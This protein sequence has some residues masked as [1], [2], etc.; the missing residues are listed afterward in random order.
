MFTVV[1][2]DNSAWIQGSVF[3][4]HLSLM[5]PFVN[6]HKLFSVNLY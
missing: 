1:C 4:A 5:S 3:Q 6:E 2:K